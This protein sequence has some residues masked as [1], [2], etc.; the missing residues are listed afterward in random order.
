M[1]HD[2][3]ISYIETYRSRIYI[4]LHIYFTCLSLQMQTQE[5]LNI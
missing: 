4:E 5:L 3:Y 1:R 2:L